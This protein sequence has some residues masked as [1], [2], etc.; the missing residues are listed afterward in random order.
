MIITFLGFG[1]FLRREGL[2]F[3]I[4]LNYPLRDACNMGAKN[5][6]TEISAVPLHIP[7]VYAVAPPYHHHPTPKFLNTYSTS[8]S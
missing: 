6:P 5:M 7:G 4:N 2:G 1:G 3:D 8:L